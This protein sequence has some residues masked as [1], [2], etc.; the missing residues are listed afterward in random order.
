MNKKLQ[1]LKG[2]TKLKFH[3]NISIYYAEMNIRRQSGNFQF[4][5]LLVKMFK[6]FEKF[7]MKF[8]C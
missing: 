1:S 4:E 7:I 8:C 5:G 2:K 3:K 6:V